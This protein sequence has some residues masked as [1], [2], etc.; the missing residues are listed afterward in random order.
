MYDMG[1]VVVKPIMYLRPFFLTNFLFQWDSHPFH[2]FDYKQTIFNW[3][4][5]LSWLQSE[6]HKLISTFCGEI[7]LLRPNTKTVPLFSSLVDS[8]IVPE[9]RF[10]SIIKLQRKLLQC[11][12]NLG[13]NKIDYVKLILIKLE[14]CFTLN[15][16][17]IQ[18]EIT[19]LWIML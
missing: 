14:L 19:L 13:M 8:S 18:R 15:L 7:C 12:N 1:T 4:R 6:K 9:S 2:S 5:K 11:T 16:R 3:K 17:S 10:Y